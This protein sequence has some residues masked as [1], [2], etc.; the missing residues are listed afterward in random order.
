MTANRKLTIAILVIGAL[1]LALLMSGC[2]GDGGPDLTPVGN[3]LALIG[4]GI[5]LAAFVLVLGGLLTRPKLSNR[6]DN[7]EEHQ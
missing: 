4:F 5:V 1:S 6:K 7:D 3:G 2:S